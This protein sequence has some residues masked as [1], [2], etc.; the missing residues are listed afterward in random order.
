MPI[1]KIFSRVL[2]HIELMDRMME[3]VGV[4]KRIRQ[5]PGAAS[6]MRRAANRCMTCSNPE[7]CAEFL[8]T[9]KEAPEPP[10]YC[11]NHD[12]FERLKFEIEAERATA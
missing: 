6:V 9:H 1:F 11:R 7:A 4:N 3:T 8:A 5:L 10:V 2:R 12:L